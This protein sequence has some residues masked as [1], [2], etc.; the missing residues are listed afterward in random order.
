[1]EMRMAGKMADWMD[2]RWVATKGSWRVDRMV[3]WWESWKAY[4][5]VDR[6]EISKAAR[7]AA[8]W[9]ARMDGK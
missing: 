6:L 2:G 7:K 1:M 4:S 3:D 9:A 8:W 5:L